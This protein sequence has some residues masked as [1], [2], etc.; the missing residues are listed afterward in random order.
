MITLCRW[1]SVVSLRCWGR[2][3]ISPF[4]LI[5]Q[6]LLRICLKSVFEWTWTDIQILNA[7][8]SDNNLIDVV[9]ISMCKHSVH[10]VNQTIYLFSL[11][12]CSC[13]HT[14]KE[15]VW[16]WNIFLIID[17]L[18]IIIWNE[19]IILEHIIKAEQKRLHYKRCIA[20][21]STVA[22]STTRSLYI[23]LCQLLWGLHGFFYCV[24]FI[25][26]FTFLISHSSPFPNPAPFDFFAVY[27]I[28]SAIQ[29]ACYPEVCTVNALFPLFATLQTYLVLCK[30]YNNSAVLFQYTRQA[31]GRVASAPHARSSSICICQV[32]C[33]QNAFFFSKTLFI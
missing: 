25:C 33:F 27:A 9:V 1:C 24:C 29:L 13:R 10:H 16:K 20:S 21:F 4:G 12:Y 14:D 23:I 22:H 8:Y 7:L 6:T 18:H 26:L 19:P 3:N 11:V 2:C 32:V 30:C 17:K 15:N 31:L 5:S 28:T